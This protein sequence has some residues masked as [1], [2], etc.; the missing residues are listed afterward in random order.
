MK[1][2]GKITVLLIL[3]L[4]IGGVFG[5]KA[6][7]DPL[8]R[9]KRTG[10][11]R[12]GTTGD[13]LPMSYYREDTEKYVGFDVELVQDLADDLGVETEYVKTS[14]PALMEDTLNGKFDI[15]ICGI[16]IT[17][18]RKETALMSDAYLENGKTILIRIEDIDKYKALDDINKEEVRVM[19]NPGGLNERFAREYL[20]QAT[21]II[22]ENNA[23]IP[24]LIG[25]GEADVMITEI[26]EAA[27]YVTVDDRLAAPLISE[28]F[29]HGELGILLPKG[30]DSVLNYVNGFIERERENGRLD[31]LAT[32]YYFR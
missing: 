18:D 11:I 28:P 5:Y 15:A 16:T 3:L 20:P 19:V 8:N 26:M 32:S 1:R 2:S 6:Y 12:V 7:N 9:I 21:L 23:E 29:T 24:F 4:I 17:E 31:A 13:Y 22:H 30:Y 14:W 10:V 27:Y 25:D